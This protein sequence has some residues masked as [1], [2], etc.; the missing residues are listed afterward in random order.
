MIWQW[1]KQ[2]TRAV[3]DPKF[4]M[5]ADR[6]G[7]TP[8]EAF[9]VFE[10]AEGWAA[11]HD[12]S[13]ARFD[14]EVVASALRIALDVAKRI[15]QA[16]CDKGMV[17]INGLVEDVV[18]VDGTLRAWAHRQAPQRLA[19]SAPGA[20]QPAAAAVRSRPRRERQR[21]SPPIAGEAA[22]V[23][24]DVVVCDPPPDTPLEEITPDSP[25]IV[26]PA[27]GN[28]RPPSLF[29][30]ALSSS[31]ALTTTLSPGGELRP[32][33]GG[34]RPPRITPR[35]AGTNPRAL[36]ARAEPS[37]LLSIPG[38]RGQPLGSR[39][40]DGFRVPE[41]WRE[42]AAAARKAAGLPRADLAVE[43]VKFANY[44][45]AQVGSRSVKA[46]WRKTWIVWA[47]SDNVK[48]TDDPD[49]TPPGF[50]SPAHRLALSQKLRQTG[51]STLLEGELW[52]YHA[53]DYGWRREY[54]NNH[55]RTSPIDPDGRWFE[56]RGARQAERM[57]AAER[58]PRVQSTGHRV[59]A[60]YRWAW[61]LGQPMPPGIPQNDPRVVE[62]VR[63]YDDAEEAR[64]AAQE[65][66]L[67]PLRA[68]IVGDG[69]LPDG[70]WSP[71]AIAYMERCV[72]L[73]RTNKG[74]PPRPADGEPLA[75]LQRMLGLQATEEAPDG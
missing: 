8:A 63:R 4:V 5:I 15:W 34:P 50:P 32:A 19:N 29:E 40:P 65:R 56:P 61:D 57:F 3:F 26:P 20:Q 49:P 58:R 53:Y 66:A 73:I 41:D 16:L 45:P 13:L 71:D 46:D 21:A 25:P 18:V 2:D 35:M 22:G 10:A 47:L 1:F 33:A 51:Y 31:T 64:A 62:L 52:H 24:E 14:L 55:E 7:A 75:A 37:F 60:A 38:G 30:G 59:A 12:G 39:L 43:A 67:A 17:V 9:V 6:A 36:A 68:K 70:S 28:L 72:A 11:E 23:S 27:G 69:K 44:W 48:I 42:E 54:L 74:L